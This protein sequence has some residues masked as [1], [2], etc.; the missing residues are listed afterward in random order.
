MT[1]TK[2]FTEEILLDEEMEKVSGGTIAELK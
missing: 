1:H 2:I